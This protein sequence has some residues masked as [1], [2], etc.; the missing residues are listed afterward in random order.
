MLFNS[1]WTGSINKVVLSGNK[2][3]FICTTDGLFQFT[4][5][6]SQVNEKEYHIAKSYQLEQNYPNPFNPS[7]T[8]NYSIVK[9]DLVKLSVYNILGSKV[10][11]VVDEIKSAGNY[12]VNF[13]A[14]DLPS[15]IYFYRMIFIPRNGEV[16][17]DTKKLV[18][19][20]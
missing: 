9:A 11:K 15:G 8:I 1:G 3:I 6:L 17:A 5:S 13:N 19:V 20:K 18:I 12:S 4:G 16:Q 2:E 14:A 7:T 10:A